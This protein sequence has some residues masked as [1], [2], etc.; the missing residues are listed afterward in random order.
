[1]RES[2]VADLR[3]F[4]NCTV[5]V[6]LDARRYPAGGP[7]A[8]NVTEIAVGS[9]A[10]LYQ[11]FDAWAAE[12]DAVWLIAPEIGG[13]LTRWVARAEGLG[14][15]L[16]GPG[17]PF[18]EQVGDKYQ[19]ARDLSAAGV[20]SISGRL[21]RADQPWPA[22]IPFPAVVKPRRGAGC[23]GVRR[24]DDF[25][26]A[27]AAVVGADPDEAD[28][29]GCWL[30]QPF[31]TGLAASV[32][33]VGDG[34]G[35]YQLLPAC[36]QLLSAQQRPG[37]TDFSYH[38]S[39]LLESPDDA[40]RAIELARAALAVLPPVRGYLGLDLLLNAQEPGRPSARAD[41]VVEVNARL[42]TSY[43]VLRREVPELARAI[44]EAAN[45]TTR[46]VG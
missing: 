3:Q 11:A 22:E 39:E 20:R 4:P 8:L 24:C 40:R 2:L 9:L 21:W 28:S 5:R 38:G 41:Y 19:L 14:V 1:M 23:W 18:V 35:H 30:V 33:A 17:T 46:H 16:L 15:H 13:E 45:T 12:S 43:L 36:R 10:E 27:Q 32:A 42:T 7:S 31:L 44:V 37:W 29:D 26:S 6:L 25:E 34:D